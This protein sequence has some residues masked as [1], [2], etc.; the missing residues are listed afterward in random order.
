MLPVLRKAA[1]TLPD[2]LRIAAAK[3]LARP[4]IEFLKLLIARI[5]EEAGGFLH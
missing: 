1:D 4:R 5:E 2:Q 3:R